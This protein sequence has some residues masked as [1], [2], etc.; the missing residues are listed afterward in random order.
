MKNL[1][2]KRKNS[3]EELTKKLDTAEE[4]ELEDRV[5]E[6]IITE[7]VSVTHGKISSQYTY[8]LSSKSRG[9]K[10]KGK[11]KK[12][13]E[14]MAKINL[15]LMKNINQTIQ[16]VQQTQVGK[17]QRKPLLCAYASESNR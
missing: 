4:S 11:K 7:T 16:E 15:N 17:R 6:T 3:L 13:E 1:I 12:S 5:I 9:E 2:T 10:N 14:I 8:D